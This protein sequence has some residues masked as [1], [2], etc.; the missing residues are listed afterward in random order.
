M[1]SANRVAQGVGDD[2]E[3]GRDV[4]RALETDH[5][6]EDCPISKAKDGGVNSCIFAAKDEQNG[7]VRLRDGHVKEGRCILTSLNRPDLEF[8]FDRLNVIETVLVVRP[9]NGK[10]GTERGFLNFGIV[11]GGSDAIEMDVADTN[12]ISSAE[13]GANIVCAAQV[14][15]GYSNG[16]VV[17][18]LIDGIWLAVGKGL[19]NK[20]KRPTT[21]GARGQNLCIVW[22]RES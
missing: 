3:G 10:L 11:R 9:G 17:A 16:K 13:D 8:V 21:G 6:N 22:F 19:F 7:M 2:A 4:Q 18:I 5:G 14:V 12:R 15:E 1:V 20:G